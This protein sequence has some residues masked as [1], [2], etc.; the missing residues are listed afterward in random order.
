MSKWS[1]KFGAVGPGGFQSPNNG[2]KNPARRSFPVQQT[3]PRSGALGTCPDPL[4]P[5]LKR[6][7]VPFLGLRCSV[8]APL[9]LGR[10]W[11]HR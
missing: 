5:P 3:R 2:Q 7:L 9:E 10:T 4:H 11:A 6:A 8:S 1:A